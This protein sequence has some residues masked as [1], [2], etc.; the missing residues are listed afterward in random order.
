MLLAVLAGAVL[1]TR[2][3]LFDRSLWLDEGTVTQNL[4]HRGYLDLLRPLGGEQGAPVGW[5]WAERTCVHLFGSGELSLRAVSFAGSLAAL[6][7]FVPVAG[8]L[9]RP[10]AAAA[11]TWLL[12]LSPSV[13]YYAAE[14][15]QYETDVLAAVVLL[16]LLLAAADRPPDLRRGAAGG[17]AAAAACWFSHPAVLVSAAGLAGLA[18]LAAIRRVP[19]A[20]LAGLAVAAGVLGASVLAEYLVS[21][22]QLSGDAVLHAYWKAGFAP[23]APAALAGWLLHQ[24]VAVLADPVHLAHPALALAL[25][26]GGAAALVARRGPAGGLVLAAPAAG[27]AAALAGRYPLDGRL[28]LYLVP[29]ALLAL[30][31]L[32]LL[33]GAPAPGAWLL[34]ALVALPGAGQG[35]RVLAHPVDR[36]DARAAFRY[37]ARHR[38][39]GDVLLTERGWAEPTYDYY[40]PRYHL[41][42]AGTF[43]L[44][45]EPGCP[46]VEQLGRPGWRRVWV[47][48]AHHPG[49]EPADRTA[50]YLSRFAAAGT[51]VAGFRAYGD[52]GA[53]LFDLGRPPAAPPAPRAGWLAPG[54]LSVDLHPG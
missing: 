34:V 15:K 47:V 50:V 46:S 30:C 48:L 5:L 45:A 13:I 36:T 29:A 22:R 16:G 35:A 3:Y 26:A 4:L 49:S 51:Q 38:A 21:L 23:G 19:R 37:V 43:T 9:L 40:G 31:G 52:A 39:P 8:R 42:R 14:V 20:R 17:A 41:A 6:G 54:C 33:R 27:L 11:A 24:P 1:R 44:V 28:A 12:A 25:V 18:G 10:A 32:L 7:A 2:Q 53:Y